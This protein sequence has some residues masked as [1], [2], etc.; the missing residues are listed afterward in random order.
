[1]TIT[2]EIEDEAWRLTL[3]PNIPDCPCARAGGSCRSPSREPHRQAC[4]PNVA[5]S[6]LHARCWGGAVRVLPGLC[7][8]PQPRRRRAHGRCR[9]H[10]RLRRHPEGARIGQGSMR[11][12]PRILL[13]PL[14]AIVAPARP[15]AVVDSRPKGGVGAE[16]MRHLE[17]LEENVRVM[18]AD[19]ER[20]PEPVK[21][22]LA[23]ELRTNRLLLLG[24]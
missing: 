24:A 3:G 11:S 5:R 20:R 7:H 10:R 19:A 16:G 1:M 14:E 17:Q 13:V 8:G 9:V 18:V 2:V 4:G 21:I 23:T 12:G 22:G 6:D 15:A